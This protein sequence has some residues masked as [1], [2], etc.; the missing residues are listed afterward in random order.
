MQSALV[1]P[2][3][4]AATKAPGIEPRPPSTVTTNASAITERSMPRFAGSRGSVS[5]PARPGEECAEREHRGEKLRLVDAERAG[6]HRD[7]RTP[8]G[9]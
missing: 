7:F 1:T 5:A 8:R 6:E 2:M 4:I 9:R 3:M